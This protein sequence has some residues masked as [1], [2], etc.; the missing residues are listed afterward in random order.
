MVVYLMLAMT[1]QVPALWRQY[2]V[3]RALLPGV[4]G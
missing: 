3:L 4:G 1:E 2:P